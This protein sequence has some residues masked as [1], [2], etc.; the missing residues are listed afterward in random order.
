MTTDAKTTSTADA[1]TPVANTV[2]EKPVVEAVKETTKEEQPVAKTYTEEMWKQRETEWN[3][4]YG[5]LDKK[6]TETTKQLQE[7]LS[8]DEKAKF[9]AFIKDV[10]SKGADGN[11]ARGLLTLREELTRKQ[12]E[13]DS[14]AAV[15]EQFAKLQNV[16]S[17]IKEFELSDADGKV[18]EKLMTATSAEAMKV[19]AL[20]VKVQQLKIAQTPVTQTDGGKGGARI[21]TSKLPITQRLALAA[22]GKI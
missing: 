11:F 10:E 13:I 21:D 15:V 4:R 17:L 14:K 6:L 9:D 20:E 3:S 16:Q 12:Q 2:V 7:L 19:L 5:G 18:Q 8:K 1:T 22:D